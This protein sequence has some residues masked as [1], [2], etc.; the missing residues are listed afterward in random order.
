MKLDDDNFLKIIAATP[1]VSIDLIVKDRNGRILMGRRKN[2]P[3]IRAWFVP[4]GRIRKGENVDS[5]LTRIG[6]SELGIHLTRKNGRFLGVFDHIY[7]TN[8]ANVESI[9][10]QYVVL[11][12]E[13]D[14]DLDRKKLP[15][16]QHS[17]WKWVCESHSGEAHK[18]SAAYFDTAGGMD[19]VV[20]SVLNARRDAFNNMLWQTPVLS[21]LAQAFLFAIIL[22]KDTKPHARFVA[23]LLALG[24][25]AA[26]LHLLVKHR[27][28]EETLARQLH[29]NE[30]A[31]GRYPANRR[32]IHKNWLIRRSSYKIW[33]IILLLFGIAS[34]VAIF[35]PSWLVR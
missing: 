35:F 3:A 21:L 18:Y 2:R 8:F 30:K 32:L 17:D 4:G 29:A 27:K 15:I 16:D 1:L 25:S 7:E 5:A 26:S 23:A 31:T 20:Y 33:L 34:L 6:K 9:T 11:A 13:Y 12:Y 24:T 22:S 10:T 28:G 14:R 19:D